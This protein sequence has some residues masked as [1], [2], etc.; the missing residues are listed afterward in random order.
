MKL[1]ALVM[2]AGGIRRYLCWLGEPSEPPRS[3]DS[4]DQGLGVDVSVR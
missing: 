1:R 3:G 2:T 4:L